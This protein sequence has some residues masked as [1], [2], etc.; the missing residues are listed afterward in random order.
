[1]L[2]AAQDM[3]KKSMSGQGHIQAPLQESQLQ[4]TRILVCCHRNFEMHLAHC[5]VWDPVHESIL[6]RVAKE[7]PCRSMQ[8][9]YKITQRRHSRKRQ[10]PIA[11]ASIEVEKSTESG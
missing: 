5:S 1:M 2:Q 10:R 11:S 3:P 9:V 6:L 7:N 8:Q 4:A